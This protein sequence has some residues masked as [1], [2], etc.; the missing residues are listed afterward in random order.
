M[1]KGEMAF[2]LLLVS[3]LE[4]GWNAAFPT[5]DFSISLILYS[6]LVVVI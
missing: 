5:G 1:S 2:G 3:R 4:V 6:L